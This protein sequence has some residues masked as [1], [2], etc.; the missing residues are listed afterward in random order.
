MTTELPTSDTVRASKRVSFVGG[1]IAVSAQDGWRKG[2]GV[3]PTLQKS[4]ETS[5]LSRSS[6]SHEK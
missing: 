3:C 5:L 6:D 2:E 1:W 4:K